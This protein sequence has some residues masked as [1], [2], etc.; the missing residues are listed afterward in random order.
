MQLTKLGEI[1][2]KYVK[3][4]GD[5]E[6]EAETIFTI[7]TDGK[8]YYLHVIPDSYSLTP[9]LGE[10]YICKELGLYDLDDIVVNTK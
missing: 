7:L 2:K 8:N 4:V 9:S 1:K 10:L 5:Q 3:R 6:L